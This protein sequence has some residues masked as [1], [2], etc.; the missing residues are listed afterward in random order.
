[1]E[2]REAIKVLVASVDRCKC[3]DETSV[4]FR[5][6]H[7]ADEFAACEALAAYAMKSVK[8]EIEALE[9]YTKVCKP[10]APP[11]KT[12][13]QLLN[14]ILIDYSS[15]AEAANEKVLSKAMG[16]HK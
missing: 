9:L 3:G 15:V 12:V 6:Y 1:M 10:G 13:P 11:N 4:L 8:V 16:I 14:N 7:A 5:A 2:V